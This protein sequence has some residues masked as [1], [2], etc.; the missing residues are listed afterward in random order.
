MG[1]LFSLK[2]RAMYNAVWLQIH[3]KQQNT[4]IETCQV[5][6]TRC[7]LRLKLSYV[8]SKLELHTSVQQILAL[9]VLP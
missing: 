5:I 4:D 3:Q 2:D 7:P 8:S 9:Y 1:A 6:C